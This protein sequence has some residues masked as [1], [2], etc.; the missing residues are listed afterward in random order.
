ML[1]EHLNPSWMGKG[2][3]ILIFDQNCAKGD[4]SHGK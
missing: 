1:S 2:Y 3:P 4:L